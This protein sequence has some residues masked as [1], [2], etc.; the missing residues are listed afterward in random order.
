MIIQDDRTEEQQGILTMGVVGT[1]PWLSGFGKARGGNSYAVWACSPEDIHE[2][3]P[4][5]KDKLNLKRVRIVDLRK[6]RPRGIGHCHIYAVIRDL[7][8]EGEAPNGMKIF[9]CD[10][11]TRHEK[12]GELSHVR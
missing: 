1:D 6:Y 4:L 5:I 3:Y 10:I 2:L 11:P 9:R 7:L 8:L 12:A